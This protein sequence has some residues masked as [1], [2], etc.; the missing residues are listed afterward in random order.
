MANSKDLSFDTTFLKVFVCGD[1]GTGKSIFASTFP[2][3]GFLFDFDNGVKSY[4]GQ[5]FEYE[6]YP[7]T[8][9]GWIKFESDFRNMKLLAKDP[10]SFPYKTIVI[11][12]CSSWTDLAMARAMQLD[13]KR[14]ATN[15]PLWNV[16]YGMVKNLIE[17]F[18]RQVLEFPCNLVVAGHLTREFDAES[19]ALIGIQPMLT[20]QLSTKVPSL[21]D[22]VYYANTKTV[23]GKTQF[24]L[25]T[26]AKG[27][28]KARSRLSGVKQLLPT[29]IE[30]NYSAIMAKVKDIK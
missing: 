1:S 26:V 25:L 17:G 20:G 11:D 2:Q 9:Q 14:S 28:L 15:G 12:S 5:D 8:P 27:L 7:C 13:P 4:K 21:F 18:V 16:H 29:E 10:A 23:G 3:P 24:V 19:G 22:E 30:N 6:Q